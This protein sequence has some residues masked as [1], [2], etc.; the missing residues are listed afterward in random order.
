MRDASDGGGGRG[1]GHRIRTMS[2]AAKTLIVLGAVLVVL[3]LTGVMRADRGVE[4]TSEEAADIA[5]PEI[6]FEPGQTTVRL[7]REGISLDPVWAVSFSIENQDDDGF[8]RLTV[9][10]VDAATGEILGVIHEK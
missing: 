10:R 6:D 3:A 2:R 5:R 9:I 1:I 4:I 7:V 8:E